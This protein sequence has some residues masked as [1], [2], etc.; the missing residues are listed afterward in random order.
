[1]DAPLI[2]VIVPVYKV[3]A[4][5]DR[6][7]QS[8]VNQTYSHLE[9][10]LVDDGSPDH[11]GA[12]C[13]AWAEKESRIQVIHK[14]NGG[15]TSARL[16][17]VAAATGNWIG[18]VDGDDYIEPDMYERLLKNALEHGVDISHCG[19]R[20]VFPSGR[21][22]YYYN[23]GKKLEQSH[24]EALR[25]L[26]EGRFVEPALWNKLFRRE[27]FVSL[28][29]RM[30]LSIRIIEDLL[31]NYWL[32]KAANKAF[33]EDFCPYHY[34]L[35]PGS[36]STSRISAHKLEDPLRVMKIIYED[37]PCGVSLTR[38]TRQLI[39]LASMD[40]Q[41]D[42]ELIRPIRDSARK[43]LRDRLGE[44]LKAEIGIKL[45]VMALWTAIWPASYGW[46]HSI[47]DRITGNDKK[48]DLG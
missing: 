40:A 28:Q 35:R 6:C 36:A 32:F 42:P 43:E 24:D 1:M 27:L 14:E 29:E 26:V 30:D 3:E 47:Y 25:D 17:G 18:F 13:D 4:Y 7:V 11:C 44:I 48:Y 33:Y 8:I 15:V 38:L 5:L 41:A 10:I 34:M 20:M 16:R 31:M 39:F 46:V 2:S 37:F 21:V 22:D 19:Y 9:I 12:M 45:K 23:T